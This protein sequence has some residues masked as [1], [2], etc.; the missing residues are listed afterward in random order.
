MPETVAPST[1][2]EGEQ[3]VSNVDSGY[4][5]GVMDEAFKSVGGEV[6]PQPEVKET[7]KENETPQEEP[8]TP[9]T[10]P[11]V[12][13]EEEPKEEEKEAEPEDKTELDP[14][15][16]RQNTW[17]KLK[18]EAKEAKELREKIPALQKQ[19]EEFEGTRTELNSLR[20][21]LQEAKQTEES[22]QHELYK[23]RIT[24]TK[25]FQ[26]KV[27]KP[28]QHVEGAAIALA[29]ENSIDENEFMT[30]LVRGDKKAF[31]EAISGLDEFDR[32]DA[33]TMFKDMRIIE[34]ERNRLLEHSKVIAQQ[35]EQQA[36]QQHELTFKQ[37]F[38]K[39]QAALGEI[40][41]GFTKNVLSLLPEDKRP[42]MHKIGQEVLTFDKWEP[43]L[44]MYGATAAIIL[45]D[46][47][48]GNKS[49][50]QELKE[51][52]AEISKLRKGSP[53]V[54]S[55]SVPGTKDKHAEEKINPDVSLDD[56]AHQASA[57]V[58]ASLGLS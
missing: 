9:E 23:S 35:E 10:E 22:I 34:S 13:K 54:G 48:E 29:K 12:E 2:A 47:I 44:Q 30:L 45:P 38:E 27:A 6:E 19:I 1:S 46:L 36:R 50:Q 53:K 11:E 58:R 14:E 7:P 42:D 32:A 56:F 16:K 5:Q 24:A 52:K 18:K 15:E 39:R 43:H 40:V 17:N 57:R 41:P 31:K 26:D 8:E 49:L 51:A 25:V 28:F 20:Q 33:H 37:T 55:G 3:A 4:I 21:Q